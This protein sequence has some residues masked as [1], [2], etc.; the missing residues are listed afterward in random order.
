MWHPVPFVRHR[1][2]PARWPTAEEAAASTLFSPLK[3]GRLSLADRT[4]VPAMVPWRS[5]D[6]GFVTDDVLQWYERF[7]RGQPGAIVV[8]A[9]GVRDVASGPRTTRSIP[10]LWCRGRDS[11][12]HDVATA[13]T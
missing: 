1:V 6:E 9:T 7:A 3:A 8:E 2:E 5:T 10:Q 11:N 4:W 12:P 13:R